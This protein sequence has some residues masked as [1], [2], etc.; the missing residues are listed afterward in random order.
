[1]ECFRQRTDNFPNQAEIS[2]VEKDLYGREV[3]YWPCIETTKVW[4]F[5]FRKKNPTKKPPSSKTN[6]LKKKWD[7]YE[8]NYKKKFKRI[9][10][11]ANGI[12][13]Y[14]H[15]KHTSIYNPQNWNTLLSKYMQ[16]RQSQYKLF[17]CTLSICLH[18]VWKLLQAGEHISGLQHTSF[19]QTQLQEFQVL[20]L[21]AACPA[22]LLSNR[23]QGRICRNEHIHHI[24]TNAFF[25]FQFNVVILQEH[26]YPSEDFGRGEVVSKRTGWSSGS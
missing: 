3:L 14:L 6:K 13:L 2:S 22:S 25:F 24:N 4:V 23:P 5:T 18:T 19:L 17:L 1:M 11:I 21:S 7:S 10:N 9:G 16:N 15:C 26:A 20:L 8:P 12:L